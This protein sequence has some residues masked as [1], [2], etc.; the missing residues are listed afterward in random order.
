MEGGPDV[1]AGTNFAELKAGVQPEGH[2]P[3]GLAHRHRVVAV[4]VVAPGAWCGPVAE[5]R[6]ARRHDVDLP[7]DAGGS[8]QDRPDPGADPG[9]PLV[10]STPPLVAYRPDDEHVVDDQPPRRSMPR[11]LQHH[12]P[13]YIPAMVGHMGTERAKP[14]APRVPV[15]QRAEH[16]RRV[17]PGQ[18]E[19]LDRTVRRHQTV[20]LAIRQEP[21]VRDRRKGTHRR[22]SIRLRSS[23]NSCRVSA[24]RCGVRSPNQPVR[25]AL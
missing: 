14:E 22:C 25:V 12:R 15:Q 20:V 7:R 21:V 24:S 4:P 5:H 1:A 16:T 10:A 6:Q 23:G 9:D 3:I 13:R 18:A 17:R 11:R 2:V 19:P 8:A